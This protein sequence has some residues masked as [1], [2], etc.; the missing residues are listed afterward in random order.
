MD[1]LHR[2]RTRRDIV[3]ENANLG[4]VGGTFGVQKKHFDRVA[5]VKVINH[6]SAYFVDDRARIRIQ[7]IINST[8]K[9]ALVALW[10]WQGA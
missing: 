10:R 9:S 1:H 7:K 2:I 4:T 5:T 8:A 3:A 6:V